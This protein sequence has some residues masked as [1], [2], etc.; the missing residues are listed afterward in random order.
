M[1]T[2]NG[3]NYLFDQLSSIVDQLTENDEL[4][5]SDDGS[6]DETLVIINRFLGNNVR[7]V[8][9]RHR[10][11]PVLNFQNG[12]GYAK[13]DVVVLADQDDVWCLNRLDIIRNHFISSISR[14]DLLVL[15]SQVVDKDL[16]QVHESVFGLLK[17]GPGI[18]KNLYKNTYIGCHL[19]FKKELLNAIL[20]LPNRIPMHDVWIGIVSEILGDVT[21]KPGAT[22][23]FRRSGNN[24]TQKNNNWFVRIRWR[25]N[26][27]VNLVLFIVDFIVI[28]KLERGGR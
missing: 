28:K 15:D 14:F 24:F 10:K 25:W 7:L 8:K 16:V 22:M 18:L 1:A 2:Y 20:P 27:V 23:K 3:E 12:L 9:N 19:A 4:V 21:F 26:L 13:G 6:S 11:G 5:I 17:A